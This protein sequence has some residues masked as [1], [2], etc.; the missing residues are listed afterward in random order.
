MPDSCQTLG[1][2]FPF[3]VFC[4]FLLLC[5]RG[6]GKKEKDTTVLE[7]VTIAQRVRYCKTKKKEIKMASPRYQLLSVI[8]AA[9]QL[10]RKRWFIYGEIYRKRLP[11]H[12]IGG[13][14][15]ISQRDLDDYVARARVAALGEKKG[16]K[17]KP[18]ETAP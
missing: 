3:V 6:C 17:V 1:T 9:E 16:T 13:Q 15:C 14:I 7:T 10:N 5:R 4:N 12:R 8:Q 18:V 2:L 11:Y